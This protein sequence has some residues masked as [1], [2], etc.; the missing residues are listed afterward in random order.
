METQTEYKK[1]IDYMLDTGKR[2][3]EKAG[4]ITDIGIKKRYLTEEDI[5]IERGFS[6]LINTF[7]GNHLVFAEE[8]NFDF[9]ENDNIWVIDPIS[10]TIAFIGGLPH[11]S[12]VCS[13]LHKSEVVFAAVYDPS[14]DEMFTAFKNEGAFLN[15]KEIKVGNSVGGES[16]VFNL[17]NKWHEKPEAKD[18]WNKAYDF[19][20]CRTPSS[21]AVSYCWV[22]A[23]RYDGVIALTK[24]SF[25]EFA[26][27]LIIEEAGGIFTNQRQEK[28]LIHSDRVFAG[29][30]SEVYN[31]LIK[32]IDWMK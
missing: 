6:D 31:R 11:Y 32:I 10:A 30:S 21:F 20:A 2:I 22:A 17:S 19:N 15:G 3:K 5:A 9:Q 18:I 1:I 24:D 8:E 27:K 25:P 14:T 7:D 13:H 29:G 26:G 12:I 4:R 28:N 16:I 23:G